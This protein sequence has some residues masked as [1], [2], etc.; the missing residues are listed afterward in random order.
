[1]EQA[2]ADMIVDCFEDTIKPLLTFYFEKDE[3]KKVR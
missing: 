3:A 2:R 1:L